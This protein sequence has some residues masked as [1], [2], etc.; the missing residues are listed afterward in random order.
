ML[1]EDFK[2]CLPERIVTY[3]NDRK[4][5]YDRP[6]SPLGPSFSAPRPPV[7]QKLSGYGGVKSGGSEGVGV[8]ESDRVI[9]F[10]L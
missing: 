9:C 1:V 2:N 8:K 4:D 10:F 5:S 7:L 6:Q 3:I